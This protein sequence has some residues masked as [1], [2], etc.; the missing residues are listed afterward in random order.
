M[1]APTHHHAVKVE[2]HAK[3]FM[4]VLHD[5]RM[6]AYHEAGLETCMQ[7]QD[8]VAV[9]VTQSLAAGG[10]AATVMCCATRQPGMN[11]AK[12]RLAG[13]LVHHCK[14]DNNGTLRVGRLYGQAVQ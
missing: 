11:L 13:L 1:S 9:T 8:G 6:Q 14:A 3:G 12:T 5:S 7:L 10:E 4:R 2:D